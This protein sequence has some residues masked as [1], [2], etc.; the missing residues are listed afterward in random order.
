MQALQRID[1]L[2]RNSTLRA[3]LLGN[4][5]QV[6]TRLIPHVARSFSRVTERIG[7]DKPLVAYV[8]DESQVHTF[9]R[10]TS[11]HYLVGLSSGA[12]NLMDAEELEF[13]IGHELGH[14]AFVHCGAT[15]RCFWRVTGSRKATR[16]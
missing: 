10:E 11:R 6:N 14:A 9:V 4:A 15:N 12:V 5:V 16:R 2:R 13:V 7:I 1:V 3:R 8:F